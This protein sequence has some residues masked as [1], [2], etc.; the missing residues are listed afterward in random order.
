MASWPMLNTSSNYLI[1]MFHLV[2]WV[3]CSGEDP[4]P[5]GAVSGGVDPD[6]DRLY[7]GRAYHAGCQLPAKVVPCKEY[8]YVTNAGQVV[9]KNFFEVLCGGS[10]SWVRP[11]NSSVIPPRAVVGG[12]TSTGEVLYIGRGYS[13]ANQMI[14]KIFPREQTLYIAYEGWEYSTKHY[15]FLVES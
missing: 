2:R 13:P 6:G 7:V 1:C 12:L 10:V 3:H 5:P 15:E 9:R 8:A 11:E 4:P 14:G